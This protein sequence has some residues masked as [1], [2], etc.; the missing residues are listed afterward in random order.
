[1]ADTQERV[2]AAKLPGP[3]VTIACASNHTSMQCDDWEYIRWL[4]LLI[5]SR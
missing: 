3:V 2:V 5:M 4:K 1:M